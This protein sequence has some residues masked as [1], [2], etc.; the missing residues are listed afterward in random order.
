MTR[1]K[2]VFSAATRARM[3][4]AARQRWESLTPEQQQAH[5]ERSFA[6]YVAKHPER[7][8]PLVEH[9]ARIA[10][11]EVV[12][13]VCEMHDRRMF[14]VWDWDAEPPEVTGWACAACRKAVRDG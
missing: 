11:G 3:S 10:S 1:G 5:L 9:R 7:A 4:A 2:P 13:P 6:A 14:A 12:V 8:V